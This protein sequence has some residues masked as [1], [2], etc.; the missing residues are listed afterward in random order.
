MKKKRHLIRLAEFE[1]I[2]SPLY[3]QFFARYPET[4]SAEEAL[5]GGYA[6]SDCIRAFINKRNKSIQGIVD[7]TNSQF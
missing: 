2:Y 3:E 4:G 6:S 7:W 1:S 5:H